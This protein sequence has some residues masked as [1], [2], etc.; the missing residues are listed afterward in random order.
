ML[1]AHQKLTRRLLLRALGVGLAGSSVGVGTVA[2]QDDPTWP[3]PGRGRDSD[4]ETPIRYPYPTGGEYPI[5]Y[6]RPRPSP[7]PD[8]SPWPGRPV[9]YPFPR[10]ERPVWGRK[11]YGWKYYRCL[12]ANRGKHMHRRRGRG[13]YPWDYLSHTHEPGCEK[14]TH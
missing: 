8:P 4:D 6:P 12:D 2:A 13:R 10:P 7:R 5:P 9:E 11:K 14:H 1:A 3:Y